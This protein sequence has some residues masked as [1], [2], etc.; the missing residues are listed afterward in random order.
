MDGAVAASGA[1]AAGSA[2]QQAAEER[3]DG[4]ALR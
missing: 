4:E 3:E 1:G 2:D